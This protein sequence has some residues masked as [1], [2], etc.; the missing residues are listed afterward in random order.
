MAKVV[1]TCNTAN[2]RFGRTVSPVQQPGIAEGEKKSA[3]CAWLAY[4][5]PGS[6]TVAPEGSRLGLDIRAEI[7][8]LAEGGCI[9]GAWLLHCMFPLG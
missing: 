7:E 5:S 3:A 1:N 6:S 8:G 4:G 2:T 9:I